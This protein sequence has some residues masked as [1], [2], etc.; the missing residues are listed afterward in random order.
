[1][2]RSLQVLLAFAF[3]G[4]SVLVAGVLWVTRPIAPQ[5]EDAPEPTVVKTMPIVFEAH[6]FELP[7][8]GLVEAK[9]RATLAAEVPGRVVEVSPAFETGTEVAEGQWLLRLD[10]V[11]YEAALAEAESRLAEAEAAFAAEQAR[12]DQALRDW[13]RLGREGEPPELVARRPQLESARARAA[14]ASAAVAKAE[15]DL[16]RTELRAPF[17]AVVASKGT[18]LGDYLQPGRAVAEVFATQPYEIRLPL[19]VDDSAF[20]ETDATGR[21]TGEVELRSSASGEIRRWPARIVRDTGEVDRATRSVHLVAEIEAVDA[22][23]AKDKRGGNSGKSGNALTARPG[24]F[25]EASI[26]SRPVEGLAKLPFRA[27]R[28]IG[29]ETRLVVVDGSGRIRFRPVEVVRREGG[30]LFVRGDLNPAD[31]A[32]LTELPDLIDGAEVSAVEVPA[33]APEIPETELRETL[34]SGSGFE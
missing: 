27:F 11:D 2:I 19:S 12:A 17:D 25:V 28:S 1:M 10:P 23:D 6:R 33:E 32:C 31:R 18:E 9:R 34:Q 16:R 7:S 8:Q 4:G 5:T 30:H 21:F 3:V 24:L 22:K 14:A 13:S 15:V 26:V 29:S 20:L